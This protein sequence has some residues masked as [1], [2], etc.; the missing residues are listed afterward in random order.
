MGAAT[1]EIDKQFSSSITDRLRLRMRSQFAEYGIGEDIPD[2]DGPTTL[3]PI[4]DA[5]VFLAEKIP[6]PREIVWGVLHQGSK[7]VL[8]GGSKTF[9]TWTLLDL[10]VSVAAGEPWLSFK[11]S[12]GRVCFL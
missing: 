3:P 1:T 6:V 8:G 2:V 4:V 11:T 7:I 12:K 9:K 5:A 10:A